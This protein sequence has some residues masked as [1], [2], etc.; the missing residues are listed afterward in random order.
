MRPAPRHFLTMSDL[1]ERELLT[2]LRQAARCKRDR[3]VGARALAG[4]IVAL[5]FQKPSMRTR[6]AFEV[7]VLQLGGSVISLGQEDIQLGRREPI[8]DVARVLS[9]YVD[10]IVVR[11][12][13]H[14]DAEE[15]AAYASVP[16]INGLSD[17]AHP[18]QALAD[19][20][21]LQ[22]TF[23]RLRG[24]R[25]AYIGD[26]NN[27]LHSLAGGCAML[28][29]HLTVSTPAGY[30]PNGAVWK[31]ATRRASARGALIRW[32]ADPRRAVL[33]AHAVY[34]DVWVS[35]GQERERARRL[36]AFRAFRVTR[37]LLTHAASGCRVM[38]CLPA[39]RGEE[40]TED[41][42]ESDR[43]LIF[44]QAENRLHVQKA[45]LLMLLGTP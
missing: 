39:H 20:L 22:E 18:C 2:V 25:L 13:A 9:R 15:V 34:T 21:T 17:L 42:M 5:V 1:S 6:V 28:G 10:A 29:V 44:E 12:F 32:E 19:F 26:G 35:M 23:G 3:T 33:G 11:T 45:L 41:V 30:R 8:N 40:I 38:H 43:S 16:V 24:L 7:A 27:V 4:R 14:R 37:E 36:S 31:E